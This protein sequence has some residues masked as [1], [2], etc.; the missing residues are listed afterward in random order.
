MNVFDK[1]VEMLVIDED[2]GSLIK[3][4]HPIAGLPRLRTEALIN[5]RSILAHSVVSTRQHG[6]I[7]WEGVYTPIAQGLIPDLITEHR[8]WVPDLNRSSLWHY[9]LHNTGLQ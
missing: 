8:P 9:C 5:S 1:M 6:T 2:G 3:L 7:T 4:H